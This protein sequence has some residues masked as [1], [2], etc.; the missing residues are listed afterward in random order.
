M[1]FVYNRVESKAKLQQRIKVNSITAN[2]SK[3]VTY[4]ESL[5]GD[6]YKLLIPFNC[7]HIRNG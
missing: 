1:K 7:L 2:Y 4:K 6:K 5:I 3:T